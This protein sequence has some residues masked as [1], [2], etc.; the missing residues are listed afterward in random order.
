MLLIVR[1]SRKTAPYS[2]LFIPTAD[3]SEQGL[4]RR[5]THVSFR[6]PLFCRRACVSLPRF[7]YIPQLPTLFYEHARSVRTPFYI[8]HP[9][10]LFCEPACYCLFHFSVF[11]CYKQFVR[12]VFL[13]IP[14]DECATQ[15]TVCACRILY[16]N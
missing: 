15:S 13:V 9:L 11:L 8:P 7:F 6:Y 3:G 1:F 2:D 5:R 4:I 10:A 14:S 12:R 16:F